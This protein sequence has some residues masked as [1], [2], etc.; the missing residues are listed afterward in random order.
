M[1]KIEGTTKWLMI[2]VAIFLDIVCIVLTF[3]VIGSVISEYIGVIGNIFYFIWFWIKGIKFNDNKRLFN[4]FGN[5]LGEE[6]TAGI[7]PGF[8]IMVLTT[9]HL[10]NKK[11]DET[12]LAGQGKNKQ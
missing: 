4:F 7:Y 6:I 12:K 10:H 1:K 9:I 2:G 3:F 5:F 8:L 11:V